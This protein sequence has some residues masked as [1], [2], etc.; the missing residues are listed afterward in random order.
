MKKTLIALAVLAVSGASFAQ[1][2]V[3]G[4]LGFAYQKDSKPDATA[5]VANKGFAV[6]DGDVGFAATED[7]GGG[8]SAK[9]DLRVKLR[10]RDTTVTAR[11]AILTLATPVGALTAGS[12]EEKTLLLSGFALAND[13]KDG[14]E[15]LVLEY[16]VNHDFVK[17]EA[18]VGPVKLSARYFELGYGDD[19]LPSTTGVSQ[20]TA[21]NSTT[22]SGTTLGLNYSAG[23]VMAAL[24]FTSY[25]GVAGTTLTATPKFLTNSGISSTAKATELYDGLYRTRIVGSYDMGVA[26]VAAGYE[27]RS[28]NLAA[29]YSV[30]VSAPVGPMVIGLNYANRA[31]QSSVLGNNSVELVAAQNSRSSTG[32]VAQYNL[33]KTAYVSANYVTYTGVNPALT[34]SDVADKEYKIVFMKSF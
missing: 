4:K 17:F 19:G 2:V 5:T 10:G 31:A 28:K 3:S 7:L 9:A 8:M 22:I 32:L 18:P 33:S 29:M 27:N 6:S 1:V 24:D 14:T 25:N 15:T 26:K 16:T 11:D 20:S 12:V 34:G 21:G 23:P 13:S 30:G